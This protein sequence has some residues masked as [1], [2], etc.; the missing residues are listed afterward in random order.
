MSGEV[1]NLRDRVAIVT[2][3]ASGI[4]RA[5][6][7]SL[8]EA[9]ARV[10]VVDLD[11]EAIDRTLDELAQL[12]GEVETL[13]ICSDVRQESDVEKMV[14][15]VLDRFSRIDVLVHSAGI[16][17]LAGTG[18]KI[19]PE[20]SVEEFDQ[21]VGTNLRGTILCNRAVLPTMIQQRDGQ[22]LNISST[23]GRKGRAFDSVYCA[24]KF[25]VVGLTESLAEEVRQFGIKVQLVLPDAVATP[26]WDQNGPVAAPDYSLSPERV[27]DVILYMLSLPGDTVLENVVISPL[28]ARRRKRKGTA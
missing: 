17:R 25:G 8:A 20:T 6:C 13:G 11:R 7:R 19:L 16:L 24:S 10:C 18:P 2:G 5:T 14:R 27:A 22:I 12:A 26:L 1:E 15:E 9:R 23:S 4:G 21:V 28:R 3:G